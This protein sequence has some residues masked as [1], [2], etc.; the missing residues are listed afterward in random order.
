MHT[1]FEDKGWY[2]VKRGEV[3]VL[4]GMFDTVEEAELFAEAYDRGARNY[5]EAHAMIYGLDA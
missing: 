4:D 5:D 3:V 1:T 2:G